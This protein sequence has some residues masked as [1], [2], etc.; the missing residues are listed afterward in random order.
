MFKLTDNSI[1]TA[2]MSADEIDARQELERKLFEMMS[3]ECPEEI[4]F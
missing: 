4:K 2:I 3:A 1:L